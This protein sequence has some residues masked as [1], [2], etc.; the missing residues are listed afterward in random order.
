MVSCRKISY[1]E[2][3]L[4]RLNSRKHFIKTDWVSWE[5]DKEI[6]DLQSFPPK[7]EEITE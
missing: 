4:S 1:D 7:Q 3:S 6:K 2:C 5:K